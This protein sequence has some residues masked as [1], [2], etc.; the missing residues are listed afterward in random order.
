[1]TTPETRR[2]L[3]RRSHMRKLTSPVTLKAKCGLFLVA[4]SGAAVLLLLTTPRVSSAVL[5]FLCVWS[6]ARAYYFAFYVIE[7][8]IDPSYRF[9]GVGLGRRV[10]L[11]TAVHVKLQ[12]SQSDRL[13]HRCT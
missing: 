11:A 12:S 10:P 5:L 8:Y 9:S 6:F 4:G 2:W 1:M 3:K 13:T 7:H